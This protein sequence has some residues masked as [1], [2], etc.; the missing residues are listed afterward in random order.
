MGSAEAA[1]PEAIQGKI[2]LFVG[3]VQEHFHFLRGLSYQAPQVVARNDELLKYWTEVKYESRKAGR[4]V[5]VRLA[6]VEDGDARGDVLNI[7]ISKFPHAT[8]K[9]LLAFDLFVEKHRPEIGAQALD[10][11]CYEGSFPHRVDSVLR[12]AA[13][14]LQTEARDILTG[15]RWEEGHYHPWV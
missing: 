12:L 3:R 8:Y 6:P 15:D 14:L 5:S 1:V 10:P 13:S 7:S 4:E 9:D 11:R 2:D